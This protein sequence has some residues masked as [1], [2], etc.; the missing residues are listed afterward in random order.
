VYYF[1]ERKEERFLMVWSPSSCRGARSPREKKEGN[2]Q[3]KGVR[4]PKSPAN[5]ILG[6]GLSPRTYLLII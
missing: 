4:P 3:P 1:L 5:N 2:F 6:R